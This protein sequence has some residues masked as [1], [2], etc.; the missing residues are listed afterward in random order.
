MAIENPKRL[1]CEYE[2]PSNVSQLVTYFTNFLNGMAT[3]PLFTPVSGLITDAKTQ[4]AKLLG[5]ELASKVRAPGSIAARDIELLATDI[6]M[7]KVLA[8]VQE[9]GDA[10][11]DNARV[12]FEMHQLKIVDIHGHS[13]ETLEVKHG[14]TSQT[15]EVKCKIT[16]RYAAFIW[17]ISTDKLKWYLGDYG[18]N[19]SGL[20]DSCND[21]PLEVGKLYYI[22]SQVKTSKGKGDWSQIIEKTCI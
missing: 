2:K 18:P 12:I 22:K 5:S 6:I 3:D 17:M 10:D 9:A 1:I 14:K 21:A 8:K 13:T 20:I 19:A 16:A 11:L 4:V 15:F 7:D